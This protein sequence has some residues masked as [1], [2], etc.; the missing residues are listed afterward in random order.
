VHGSLTN[1]CLGLSGVPH[2]QFLIGSALGFLPEAVPAALIG[3][4]LV[5]GSFEKALPYLAGAAIAMGVIWV[6]V[7]VALRRIR[8]G[9]GTRAAGHEI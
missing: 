4:G 8:R 5:S 2:P 3:A 9:R 7:G 6:G 1:L